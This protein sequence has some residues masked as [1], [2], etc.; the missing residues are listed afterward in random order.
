MRCLHPGLM[1]PLRTFVVVVSLILLHTGV[2]A[3]DADVLTADDLKA[4]YG[5]TFTVTTDPKPADPVKGGVPGKLSMLTFMAMEPEI[6][7]ATLLIRETDSPAA[8]RKSAEAIRNEYGKSGIKIEDAP[9][10]GDYAFFFGRQ[11]VFSKGSSSFVVA[12]PGLKK[13]RDIAECHEAVTQ[14]AKKIEERVK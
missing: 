12:A 7:V 11:L 5:A 10:I 8:G 2:R 9:G 4:Y 1:S 14:L 6:R 13:E 3:G